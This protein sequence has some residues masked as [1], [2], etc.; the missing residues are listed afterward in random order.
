MTDVTTTP[1]NNQQRQKP[2]TRLAI[3]SAACAAAGDF[4]R[5]AAADRVRRALPFEIHARIQ[6]RISQSPHSAD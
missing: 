1:S 3:A 2:L 5:I 4:A 6:V